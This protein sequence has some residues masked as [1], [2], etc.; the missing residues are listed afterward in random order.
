MS[1]GTFSPRTEAM[2]V[3]AGGL[4]RTGRPPYGFAPAG[5][6]P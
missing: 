4:H 1:E 2:F 3:G 6:W 5:A